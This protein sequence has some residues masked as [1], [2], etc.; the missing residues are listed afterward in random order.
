MQQKKDLPKG[1]PLKKATG[2]FEPPI[3]VLQTSALPLGYVAIYDPNQIRTGVTAVKGRCL[4]HLTMGPCIMLSYLRAA[5]N[6]SDTFIS[7][8]CMI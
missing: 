8:M 6:R 4:N 2:G 3:K 1:G 5:V 7:G